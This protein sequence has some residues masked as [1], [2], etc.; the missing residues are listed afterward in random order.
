MM[1][2]DICILGA[3]FAGIGAGE[4][5]HESGRETVLIEQTSTWGGLCASFQVQGFRFD[6]AVH[7]SFTQNP[8]TQERFFSQAHYSHLPETTNY[9]NGI[10]IRHPAQNNLRAFPVEERVKIIR[11][12]IDRPQERTGDTYADWLRFAFGDYF[13]ENYPGRYTR[14]YWGA[15]AQELSDTWC[16]TRVYQPSLDEVLRGAFPDAE[17][18]ENVY[19]A[20]MMHYPKTGGYRAFLKKSA[21]GLDIRCNHHVTQIDPVQHIVRLNHGKS[22]HYQHLVSTLPLPEMVELMGLSDSCVQSAA[23]RLQATS[24]TLVSIGFRRKLTF[25]AIWFYV[26]DEEIPFARVHSPSWKSPDN[27]PEGC[28]S[29]EFEIYDSRERPFQMDDATLTE[30]VLDCME[31]M[32]L[33]KRDDVAVCDCRHVKYANVIYYLGMEHERDIVR[34]AIEEKGVIMCGR[35]GEWGYLW[36]DQSYLSGRQAVMRVLR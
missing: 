24:M 19:Y 7:L 3:G 14:K 35:F 5:A 22:C 6:Q 9:S 21:E 1:E 34:H 13:A 2:T 29:L 27:A 36:S 8:L 17:Q 15:E 26:Y 33:A 31:Q 12:F 23:S 30:T 10:W 32:H 20:K 11:G 28:S 16:G 25:P 4:A 18:P